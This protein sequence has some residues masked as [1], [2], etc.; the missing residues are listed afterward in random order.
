[1]NKKSA[2]LIMATVFALLAF[3]GNSVLCRIA[4]GQNMIDAASFTAIRLVSGIIVLIVGVNVTQKSRDVSASGSWFAALMLFIYA[5]TFSF[6]YLSIQTGT[7]ALIL[8]GSVQMT[9][10]IVSVVTGNKPHYSEWLGLFMAFSGFVYLILPGVS[11]PP[12]LG[13]ALMAVSGIAWG[14]YTLAGKASKDPLC[15]TAYNF[16]RTSPLVLVLVVF[17]LR[18]AQLSAEGVL[19][20]AAS[21]ALASALGYFAWY[22]ALRALSVAQAA[23]LQLL[24]PVI[25]AMGGVIFMAEVV[26]LRLAGASILVLGGIVVV[27]FGRH[28][29]AHRRQIIAIHK[30]DS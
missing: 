14:F 28:Y 6:G 18:T 13:F 29:C 21:G 1:M 11:T 24:V 8:F 16:L 10:M 3:A 5:A 27:I 25:A 7:G 9:M 12:F 23:A 30:P 17:A 20:A 4:L 2:Q 26:T 15:D 22:V 19:L